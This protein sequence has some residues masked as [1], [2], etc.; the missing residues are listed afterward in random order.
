MKSF[1][2]LIALLNIAK[3]LNIKLKELDR[4]RSGLETKIGDQILFKLSNQ[5][6]LQLQKNY[7]KIS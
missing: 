4:Q 2:S 1:S 6:L 3:E 5:I 7:G